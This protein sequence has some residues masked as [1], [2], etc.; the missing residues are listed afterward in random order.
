MAFKDAKGIRSVPL[1]KV[2]AVAALWAGAYLCVSLTKDMADATN[3]MRFVILLTV[4]VLFLLCSAGLYLMRSPPVIITTRKARS[5]I[6]GVCAGGL[7][8]LLLWMLWRICDP[9]RSAE[10]ASVGYLEKSAHSTNSLGGN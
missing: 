4:F 1:F 7:V 2:F 10:K 6:Y 3:N 8:L 5:W 9:Y